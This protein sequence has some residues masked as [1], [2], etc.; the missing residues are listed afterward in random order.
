MNVTH[1]GHACVLIELGDKPIR[2]LIDPGSY[3]RDFEDLRDLDLI[4][5]THAHPDH[6]DTNRLPALL[7]HNPA[8]RIVHGHSAADALADYS[9]RTH[10]THP[11]DTVRLAGIEIAVTGGEH[12]CVHPDLPG[13]DNNGYLIAGAVFH[14]GDAFDP[15]PAAVDTL[16]LPAGGPWM[17][18]GEGVDYL[19]AVAPRIAIPIHQA[20]L[21]EVH[22]RMHHHL[23]GSLAPE[24]TE[25]IVLEHAVARTL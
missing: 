14:P 17:K 21:A 2:V 25:V 7:E 24:G 1:Y 10:L 13:S 9:A 16:L 23:L 11:G 20:G 5:F 6:L 18:V 22:Q 12:A 15:P 19:R 4:L 8:A 3:S